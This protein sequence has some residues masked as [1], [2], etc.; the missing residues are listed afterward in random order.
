MNLKA[1]FPSGAT[2]LTVNGLHQWDYGRKLDIHAPDLPA[3]VEVHFACPGMD[4]AIVRVSSA[5]GG[6]A[7]VTI[8]DRCLEQSSPVTAWVYEVGETSGQTIKTL[9]LN[10][11]ARTRPQVAETLTPEICDKYTEAVGAMNEAIARMPEQFLPKTGGSINGRLFVNGDS[12]EVG[13]YHKSNT[14]SVQ[15]LNGPSSGAV[16]GIL[17]FFGNGSQANDINI[18]EHPIYGIRGIY[19]HLLCKNIIEIT[20]EG[21]DGKVKFDG[22]A[23]NAKTAQAAESAKSASSLNLSADNILLDATNTDTMEKVYISQP[24]L[25]ALF[26]RDEVN[27]VN[28]SQTVYVY[29]LSRSFNVSIPGGTL[30]FDP[31]GAED[32]CFRAISSDLLYHFDILSAVKIASI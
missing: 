22:E 12:L 15:Y 10:V 4:E 18:S 16:V 9:T 20:G 17:G 2:E 29:N 27:K 14:L 31:A 30:V 11:K 6:V 1:I 32:A 13:S 28:I 23:E 5:V 25:Y 26:I 19:D 21:K 24:G 7:T 8:P 3:L